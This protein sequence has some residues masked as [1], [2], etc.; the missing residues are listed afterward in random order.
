MLTTE[1]DPEGEKHRIEDALSD[2]TK[3]QHPGPVKP[4]G[5]PLHWDVDKRHGNP[6]GKDDSEGEKNIRKTILFIWKAKH[7]LLKNQNSVLGNETLH[8]VTEAM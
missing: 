1:D 8:I 5:K 6:K 7:F 4:N 2:I 3:Q